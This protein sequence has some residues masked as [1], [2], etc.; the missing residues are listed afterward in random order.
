MLES[1][2]LSFSWLNEISS[3]LA[4]GMMLAELVAIY[5]GESRHS[6]TPSE[7]KIRMTREEITRSARTLRGALIDIDHALVDPRTQLRA[8]YYYEKYGLRTLGPVGQV[9][10]AEAEE[11]PEVAG[12]AVEAIAS[13]WDATVYKLVQ[14]GVFKGCSV[15]QNYRLDRC[16][17]DSSYVCDA[18]GVSYPMVSLILEGE[19]AFPKTIVRPLGRDRLS[20]GKRNEITVPTRITG[21]SVQYSYSSCSGV[22]RKL[23][24]EYYRIDACQNAGPTGI[25]EASPVS[26]RH[27]KCDHS[28]FIE[29]LRSLETYTSS[30]IPAQI[31]LNLLNSA[32]AETSNCLH[33]ELVSAWELPVTMSRLPSSR[34]YMFV[35]W[36]REALSSPRPPCSHGRLERGDV[37]GG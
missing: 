15:V 3:E 11:N 32:L 24:H 10:D 26:E 6:G 13:I 12:L 18:V 31:Y 1:R 14:E 5:E 2:A 33:H 9:I 28:R 30:M 22:S 29:S 16:V 21:L 37:N 7:P 27:N 8:D 4:E 36:L 35:S 20:N 34:F 23:L 25:I 19:P 17:K